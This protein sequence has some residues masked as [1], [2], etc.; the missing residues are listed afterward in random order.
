MS[1]NVL[2]EQLKTSGNAAFAEKRY[3]DALD[4]YEKAAEVDP[5]NYVIYN[6]IAACY[7]QLK[8]YD[9]AVENARKSLAINNNAKA[10]VRL[11]AALWEQKKL[12]EAKTAYEA[13]LALEPAN[14]NAKESAM[15]LKALL[16]PRTFMRSASSS[17]L[18]RRGGEFTSL[19]NDQIGLILDVAV[20]AVCVVSVLSSFLM[21]AKSFLLWNAA[22]VCVMAQQLLPM[23]EL[24]L[25][26]VSFDV[27]KQ[28][29]EKFCATT[30]GVCVAALVIGVKP[31]LMMQIIAIGYSCMDIVNRRA[32]VQ[33]LAG[34]AFSAVE[35]LFARVEVNKDQYLLNLAT[36]E[37]MQ[38]LTIMLTGGAYFT[39]AYIQYAKYRYCNDCYVSTVFGFLRVNLEKYT[40]ASYMP[41]FVDKAFQLLVRG[42]QLVANPAT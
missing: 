40:K 38:S 9:K 13:A 6:N 31:V 12:D 34:P 27:M 10:Y 1:D 7:Q 32:A 42:M 29:P 16:D 23:S 33:R 4:K 21:P 41:A 2:F 5:S 11:G 30:F 24:G 35:A 14:A 17:G 22:L 26:G 36:L 18:V 19:G 8:K 15:K 39:L 20:I 28:W 3:E 25:L 37:V